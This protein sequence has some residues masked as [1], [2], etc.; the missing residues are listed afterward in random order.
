MQV[1]DKVFFKDFYDFFDKRLIIRLLY[2]KYFFNFFQGNVRTGWQ[3]G[4]KGGMG[5]MEINWEKGM[6]GG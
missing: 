4:S 5:A 1:F 2:V 3:A 6:S